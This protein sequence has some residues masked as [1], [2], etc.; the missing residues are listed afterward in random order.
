MINGSFTGKRLGQFFNATS[1]NWR[2]ARR[3]VNGLDR[4]DDIASMARR[5]YA[6]ISYTVEILDADVAPL[7]VRDTARV[8]GPDRH[9]SGAARPP[10]AE[11]GAGSRLSTPAVSATRSV[12]WR[13]P[14]CAAA[15][16]AAVGPVAA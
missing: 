4:A 1:E 6:A 10:V 11:V 12:S 8:N 14:P 3:I 15:T 2:N 7:A 13:R 5:Y 16:A 9:R